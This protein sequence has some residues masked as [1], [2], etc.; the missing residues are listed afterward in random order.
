MHEIERQFL[1]ATVPPDLPEPERVVQ[2]YLTTGNVELR[3]RQR[4]TVH[5]LTIKVGAGLE[6]T[7]FERE[8]D[9]GEFDALWAHAEALRINKRRYLIDLPCGHLAEL[10]LF[11]GDLAG[12][13]LVEVEFPSRDDAAAFTP[14][15]WFGDEITEDA[16]Y[17]NA[18]L[19]AGTWPD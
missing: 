14:P 5:T 1:V 16:R 3:V 9:R 18:S 4:G 19:A 8:I 6:R 7:E 15:A 17:S 2:G 12:Y 10:D 11:D 13:M